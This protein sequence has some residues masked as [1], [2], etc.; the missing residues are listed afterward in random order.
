MWVCFC[1]HSS[2]SQNNKKK[3]FFYV[4]VHSLFLKT[5]P[6]TYM[7][8]F[9]NMT[10]VWNFFF[11]RMYLC[12]KLNDKIKRITCFL[13][14]F[15]LIFLK[16]FSTSSERITREKELSRERASAWASERA[17]EIA[18]KHEREEFGVDGRKK[19]KKRE[20]A[21]EG[22]KDPRTLY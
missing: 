4:V 10:Y 22:G 14:C 20:S 12:V 9:I 5:I 17:N 7:I 3:I 18:S 11:N 8:T 16:Q 1:T 2:R 19:K 21:V 6:S 13:V 15:F